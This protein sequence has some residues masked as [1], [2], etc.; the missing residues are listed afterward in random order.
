VRFFACEDDLSHQLPDAP[1]PDAVAIGAEPFF[2][3][4]AM[5]GG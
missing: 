5:A 1:L 3:I 4:G 2:V